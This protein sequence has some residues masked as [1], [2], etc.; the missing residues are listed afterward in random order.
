[1][2]S[3][4]RSE[5]TSLPCACATTRRAS[6]AVT[7]LY[8]SWLRPHGIE[9]PQFATLMLLAKH[10]R[11]THTVVGRHSN[12]DKTTL[13]RNVKLLKQ[14]GWID[15]APGPDTRERHISLT[16]TGRRR[17]SAARPAWLKAQAAL[18]ATLKPEQ[19]RAMLTVLNAVTTAAQR[20][21]R[22]DKSR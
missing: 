20:A 10:G 5:I 4:A 9:A 8:D 19:W 6:R 11:C 14:K 15:I 22:G 18:R 16:A 1:M 21:R 13:S 17:L 12:L 2:A 7:Q 3:V